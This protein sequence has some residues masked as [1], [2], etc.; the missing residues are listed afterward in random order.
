MPDR[1]VAALAVDLNPGTER[2][3]ALDTAMVLLDSVVQILA[4]PD[5]DWLQRSSGSISQA[6]FAITGNDCLMSR[7]RTQ[8]RDFPAGRL[9]IHFLIMRW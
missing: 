9:V 8:Y 2:I 6:A 3:R 7:V 4:L 5:A 1:I